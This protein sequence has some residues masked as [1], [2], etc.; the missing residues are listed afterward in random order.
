MYLIETKFNFE[1][2][3]EFVILTKQMIILPFEKVFDSFHKNFLSQC[4]D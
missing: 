4:D 1:F 2:Y 3:F